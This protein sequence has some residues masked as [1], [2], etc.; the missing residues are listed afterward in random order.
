[1]KRFLFVLSV[2]LFSFTSFAQ[3]ADISRSD[4]IVPDSIYRV[5]GIRYTHF[6]NSLNKLQTVLESNDFALLDDYAY[7]FEGYIRSVSHNTGW[8]GI[9]SFGYHQRLTTNHQ[10]QNQASLIGFTTGFEVG[11]DLT[12]NNFFSVKPFLGSGF[13][14]YKL[15]FVEGLESS[16]ISD[17]SNSDFKNYNATSFQVPVMLGLE[18]GAT[19]QINHILLEVL[20]RGGYKLHIDYDKWKIDDVVDISDEINLSSP[21]VGFSFGFSILDSYR[22]GL[23]K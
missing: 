2:M 18:V 7:S 3:D 13:E 16:S 20:V 6:T 14:Y 9:T 1:M 11:Y 12:K 8:E 4:M 15:S 21:F 5:A 22:N 23:L 19:F 17:I 10:A